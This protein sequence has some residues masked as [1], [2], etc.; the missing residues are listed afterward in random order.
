MKLNQLKTLRFGGTLLLALSAAFSA[1]ADYSSTVLSQSPA[2]YYRL[3]L[4]SQP[5]PNGTT[6]NYGTLGTSATGIYTNK[7]ALQQTGPFAGSI[8]AGFNG[9]NQAV[10]TPY[11][12]A[13][14]PS[15]FT[16]EA[17]VKP[18]SATVS[19]GLTCAASSMHSGDPRSGW[20]IYQSDTAANGGVG[21]GWNLRLYNTNSTAVSISLL[22]PQTNNGVWTHL[23]YTF[24][25]NT[26]RAYINGTLVN[27][28]VPTGTLKY[29]PNGD[30]A[31]T[32]GTRSDS[33][34][35]W[36]GQTAE[37]AFY[38]GALS[39][40]QITTHYT[41]ATTTPANYKTTVQ[42]DSPVLYYRFNEPDYALAVNSGTL[43][44]A[45][46]GLYGLGTIAGVAGPVPPTYPGFESTNSAVAFTGSG[47][48]VALPAFNFNTNT[49]TISG[50][51]N[52]SNNQFSAAGI[53]VCDSGA[54]YSGLTIDGSSA[55]TTLRLGYVWANDPNTYFWSPS[56]DGSTGGVGPF[57]PA[58][59]DSDWA[60]VALVIR[61]TQAE[62]YLGTTNGGVLT[63]SSVTN[64]LDH[65]NQSFGGPTLIGSDANQASLSFN[66]AIDEVGIWKRSLSA[67]DLYTQFASAVSGVAPQIFVDPVS[68]VAPIFVGD[69]LTLSVDAGGT[70]N[71]AYQWYSNSV[72]IGG[73]NA[74]VYIKPNFSTAA[75][76]GTYYVVVTNA[77]GSATSGTATVTGQTQTFPTIVS[78]PGISRTIYPNGTLNL[79]VVA[80]GGGLQ[81]TWKRSGT[82]LPTATNSSYFVSAVTTNNAG[83]YTV[84]VS[85]ILGGLTLGPV[86]ITVPVLSSNTYA[87]VISADAP[88]AW[89]RLEDATATTGSMMADAMA[90]HDGIYTN[91]GGLTLGAAGAVLAG[92]AAGTAATFNGDGSFGVA[93]Y[94]PIFNGGDFTLEVWAK[95]STVLNGVTVASAW[96]SGNGYG[97]GS[98]SGNWYG[99][100]GDSGT[101]YIFGQGPGVTA[102]YNPAIVPNQWVHLVVVHN[103]TANAT[104]PYRIYINGVG[105]GF[106][107]GEGTFIPNT[108][109]IIGGRGTG[110]PA[111]LDRFLTGN[112]DEVAFYNKA[113]TAAQIQSH[114]SA[115]FFGAGPII[116]TQPS[117]GT[118]FPGTN[119]TFTA[120]VAGPTPIS[121][122]WRKNGVN[123]LN[124]TNTSLTISNLFYT[125]STNIYSLR[126]TNAYGSTVSSNVTATV[127]YPPLFAYLTNG[128]VLHLA[129]EGNYNDTSGR[130]NNG[131]PQGSP[132]LV[133]G[134]IGSG[135]LSY[136]TDLGLA[137]Y[138]YVSLGS[139]TDL[140][141]SSNVSFSV[142]YWTKLPAGYTNGDLPFLS[143]AL[144]SYG[145]KGITFAP[146]YERGGWSWSL[147]DTLDNGA[148]LYGPN[149]SINNGDWHNLVHVFSRGGGVTNAL[150]YL[151][152]NLVSTVSLAGLGNIDS[153]NPF[154]IGQGA[155]GLYQ[156]GGTNTIDD[157]GIWRRAL[158]E[159][160]AKSIYIVGQNYGKS[161]DVAGPVILGLGQLPNGNYGISWQSGTLQRSTNLL[162]SWSNVAGA[163]PP[164]YQFP[165]TT[166]NTFYR[167]AP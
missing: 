103:V 63:F 135:A 88:E 73:A 139:P 3:N 117:S 76:S 125:D 161:F 69:T 40:G 30:A 80:N 33:G 10:L 50:W 107:W 93:P 115:A 142:S 49:V 110:T 132:S 113:L 85:N 145:D 77:F 36:A 16:I 152:G 90:R 39:G 34:F 86:T 143:S 141:F 14:N 147:V 111:F 127:V 101:G 27:S 163:T 130:G 43:G 35:A 137:A 66:G 160:E 32:I 51:V 79:T 112:A 45:G 84:G 124:A 44:S 6:T 29:V 166:T 75:D 81:Y 155:D 46:N 158:T 87:Q 104:Y 100:V 116:T 56:A 119:V 5:A 64:I 118:V 74:S 128:L 89:W 146:S 12:S 20:L 68:P 71:L 4:T 70:P 47:T 18:V 28:G 91:L 114:Y 21:L 48:S 99:Q 94:A 123:I 42:A 38:S 26:V 162:G 108:S 15:T 19:G 96:R 165:I 151:D 120:V 31:F 23:V 134:K 150:T 109:F 54:T 62:V 41:T 167:V 122:Q 11:Q 78:G 22:A 149:N 52:A 159:S 105:D 131:T 144:T 8:A 164:F 57:L 59:P 72:A 97:V 157:L 153:G 55:G 138:N 60:Y 154:V 92:S 24:D 58:L 65:G 148:G 136:S 1:R 126:A 121:L 156:E 7:P 53:V 82:N 102:G 98:Q 25:G 133:A 17:W 67:G 61:P 106:I 13:L 9:I 129:F 95:V 2:A 83:T 37:V 140:L